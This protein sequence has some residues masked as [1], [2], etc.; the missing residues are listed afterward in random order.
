MDVD[1]PEELHRAEGKQGLVRYELTS[2]DRR[3]GE[4]IGVRTYVL[5]RVNGRACG[6]NASGIISQGEFIYDAIH[7]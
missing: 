5:D 1:R 7:R 3:S 6:A 2:K 4:I